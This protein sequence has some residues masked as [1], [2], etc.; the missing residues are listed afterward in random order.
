MDLE[1]RV[2]MLEKRIDK[3]ESE[4]MKERLTGLK[5]G[6]YFEVA[7]T[8]WR[9]L[10]IKP[11]GYVCLSDALEERKIFDSETNNWKLSSLREYLNNDF[12]KKIAD[13][14]MEKNILPFGRD[15]LSLDGQ[16]E[17]GVCDDYD[18]VSILSVDDYRQYRKLIPNNEQW[19]W[20]LTPWSTPCNGYETQVSV[21]S[22]SGYIYY[23]YCNFI[24][25]VRPLCIFSPNLFESE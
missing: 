5:V 8:K 17:Y 21:V 3:L 4:N 16:N 15:L 10:D 25:G 11:C 19:W 24:C 9:I 23:Y 12:Y 14:I 22:P 18:Y 13:E 1:K 20:L 7:G 6:D 2:E